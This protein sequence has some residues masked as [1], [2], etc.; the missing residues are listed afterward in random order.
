MYML[1]RHLSAEVTLPVVSVQ[2]RLADGLQGSPDD[3]AQQSERQGHKEEDQIER[4]T[5][6]DAQGEK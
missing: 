3:E 6:Q 2:V 4:H 1:L 5:D